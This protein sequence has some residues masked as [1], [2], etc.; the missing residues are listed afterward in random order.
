MSDPRELCYLT[1]SAPLCVLS[2]VIAHL[3]TTMHR[4]ELDLAHFLLLKA[5]IFKK[6]CTSLVHGGTYHFHLYG[7][8]IVVL[9]PPLQQLAKSGSSSSSYYCRYHHYAFQFC[10]TR[11][12][13]VVQNGR[14]TSSTQVMASKKG[15]PIHRSHNL[16]VEAEGES[17]WLVLAE[18]TTLLTTQRLTR[19]RRRPST[20]RAALLPLLGN[21]TCACWLGIRGLFCHAPSLGANFS[22]MRS[23]RAQVKDSSSARHYGSRHCCIVKGGA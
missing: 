20:R 9:V 10:Y 11:R 23:V 19:Y 5:Y 3:R 4:P 17:V 14:K 1:L 21:R 6:P 15:A 13:S 22:F 8:R 18:T 12:L 2:N 7:Q 16:G